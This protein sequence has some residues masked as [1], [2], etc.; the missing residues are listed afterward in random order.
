MRFRRQVAAMAGI[1]FSHIR[2]ATAGNHMWSTNVVAP[3]AIASKITTTGSL[4]LAHPLAPSSTHFNTIT[5]AQPSTDS[6][7]RSGNTYGRTAPQRELTSR[8]TTN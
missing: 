7:A 1:G 4:I 8:A 2:R 3:A 5:A 6:P